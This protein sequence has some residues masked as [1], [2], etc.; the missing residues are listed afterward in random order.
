M[1]TDVAAGRAKRTL[2]ISFQRKDT[3]QYGVQNFRKWGDALE[4]ARWVNNSPEHDL[5]SLTS[6]YSETE[7]PSNSS[8]T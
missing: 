6:I 4:F 5:L 8:N 7:C 3:K 1:M 2:S